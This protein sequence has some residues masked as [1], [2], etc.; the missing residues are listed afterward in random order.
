MAELAAIY[1][2]V[3]RGLES[4]LPDELPL[5][6]GDYARWERRWIDNGSAAYQAELDWWQ[7]RLDPRPAP[8]V[9]PFARSTPA[10]NATDLDGS[11][12]V[13]IPREVTAHSTTS[14]ASRAPPTS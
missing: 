10:A 12:D 8:I 2:A 4:P 9:L 5:Q 14:V 6:M 3:Q 13:V 11:I 7:P 1:P